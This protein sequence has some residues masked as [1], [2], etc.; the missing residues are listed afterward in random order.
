MNYALLSN[1]YSVFFKNDMFHNGLCSLFQKHPVL[2]R[3]IHHALFFK[4]NMFY[5]EL[6]YIFTK[7]SVFTMN[8]TILKPFWHRAG[9]VAEQSRAEP[10]RDEPSRAGPGWAEPSQAEPS[11][12]EPSR[13]GPSRAQPSRTAPR[14]A[15]PG[16]D[17]PR[18]PR[19]SN[20]SRPGRCNEIPKVL[21]G[22]SHMCFLF[23]LCVVCVF[24]FYLFIY[25]YGS[26]SNPPVMW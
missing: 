26:M 5:D 8:F 22:R 6:C 11:R 1:I 12:F 19:E 21:W 25:I 18:R 4:N 13:A 9:P 2:Q 17:G 10:A 20:F 23:V 15:G 3:V 16:R 14:R 24:V 7:T